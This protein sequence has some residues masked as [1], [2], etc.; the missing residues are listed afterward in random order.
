MD[1]FDEIVAAQNQKQGTAKF[2]LAQDHH[3]AKDGNDFVANYI[4]RNSNIQA[5]SKIADE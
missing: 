4:L 2:Y 1:P 5:R 3:P